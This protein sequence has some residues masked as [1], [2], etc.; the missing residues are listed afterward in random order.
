[1]LG[2]SDPAGPFSASV[3]GQAA[4][5]ETELY[6]K[7][8][9]KG[10]VLV[11]LAASFVAEHL[12]KSTLVEVLTTWQPPPVPFSLLYPHQLFLSPAVRAFIDWVDALFQNEIHGKI[13][14]SN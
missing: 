8:S 13:N 7:I 5:N 14:T 6:I 9:L 2:V 12:R 1:M 4:A 11:L 3:S 10:F